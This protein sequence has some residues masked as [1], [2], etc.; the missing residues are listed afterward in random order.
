MAGDR[1]RENIQRLRNT[2]WFNRSSP[3]DGRD[4]ER[5]CGPLLPS[6]HLPNRMPRW[7]QPWP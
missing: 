6:L 5:I 2:L 4:G 1:L 3:F 7:T